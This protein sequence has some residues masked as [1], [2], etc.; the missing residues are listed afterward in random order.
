MSSTLCSGAAEV[1][2]LG[3]VAPEARV[4]AHIRLRAGRCQNGAPAGCRARVLAV[5]GHGRT[6][7]Q[8]ARSSRSGHRSGAP[9]CQWCPGLTLGEAP[10]DRERERLPG[11]TLSRSVPARLT[12]RTSAAALAP[13]FGHMPCYAEDPLPGGKGP[14]LRKL[15][16]GEGFDPRPLGYEP[17]DAR[18]RRLGPS[19]TGMLTST[20][21]TD[22]IA[23]RRLR[24]PRLTLS[25]RVRFT[26]RFTESV[27]D[28]R[29]TA[30]RGVS[31]GR[32]A[33]RAVDGFQV[34]IVATFCTIGG[35]PAVGSAP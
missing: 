19:L 29:L 34:S 21:R 7:W 27:C 17:Y 4:R 15:V 3:H 26:N 28:Q 24:L 1:R 13:C 25:R 35:G 31:A 33:G 6:H 14:D 32:L 2:V 5:G 18:L 11:S 20:D 10:R 22:P 23:H 9:I 8:S 16:A 30:L 12:C